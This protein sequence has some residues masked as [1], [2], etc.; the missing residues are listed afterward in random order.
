MT[1]NELRQR[2]HVCVSTLENLNGCMPS[3]KELYRALGKEYEEV[4]AEYLGQTESYP[5]VA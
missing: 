4:L 2:L 3:V 1:K 5:C